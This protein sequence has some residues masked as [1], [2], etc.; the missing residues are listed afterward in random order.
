MIILFLL[1]VSTLSA[2]TLEG[3]FMHYEEKYA[4]INM[5]PYIHPSDIY[6]RYVEPSDN[7]HT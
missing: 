1:V 6:V 5:V 2:L 3:N 4:H 7:I